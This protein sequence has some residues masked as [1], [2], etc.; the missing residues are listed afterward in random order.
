MRRIKSAP[1]NIATM[2]NKKKPEVIKINKNTIIEPI[3]KS[4][5]IQNNYSIKK[6]IVN[7]KKKITNIASGI[8]SD[9]FIE[10][11][12]FLPF[13]DTYTLSYF[14]EFINNF[15]INKFNRKNLE[16]FLLSIMIRFVFNEFYHDIILKVKEN[17]NVLNH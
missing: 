16:N 1:A 14:V 9:S 10:T 5:I 12:K 7:N 4:E 17:V 13:L 8:I 2:I 11:I 6:V 15:M 3:I